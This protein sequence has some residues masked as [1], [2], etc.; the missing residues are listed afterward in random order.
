MDEFNPYQAP[1]AIPVT[2]ETLADS[3]EPLRRDKELRK[4]AQ[5]QKALMAFL[6]F[7]IVFALLIGV[8]IGIFGSYVREYWSESV[9]LVIR[10][11]SFV[12]GLGQ[13]FF[14]GRLA[15]RLYHPVRAVVMIL[16]SLFFCPFLIVAFIAN[17][18]ATRRLREHGYRVGFFGADLS[19]FDREQLEPAAT[20]TPDS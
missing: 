13:P 18:G 8:A 5:C 20:H 19:Q 7:E 10:G 14:L 9:E 12:L 17:Q 11:I 6:A 16:L 4:I 3:V 1:Q 2:G 15:L